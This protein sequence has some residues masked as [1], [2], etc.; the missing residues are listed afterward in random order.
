MTALK[1][2]NIIDLLPKSDRKKYGKRDLK[3]IK[4]I[5]VHHSAM[6][7]FT[8]FDY[9]KWHIGQ[10]WPGIGYHYVIEKDGNVNQTNE[11]DTISYHTKGHNTT[12]IGISV[13]GNLSNHAPSK[14]QM[15]ALIRLIKELKQKLGGHLIVRGHRELAATECPGKLVDMDVI[16]KLAL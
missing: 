8:A 10:G 16:R 15:D 12:S 13:S 11:L 2:K 9:A 7:G 1:I 4:Q 14:E 3:L 5:V 6:D